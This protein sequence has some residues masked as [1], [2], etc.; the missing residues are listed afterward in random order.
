MMLIAGESL[1]VVQLNTTNEAN[2]NIN[3]GIL[4]S[5]LLI[6]FLDLVKHEKLHQIL[7]KLTFGR[8]VREWKCWFLFRFEI[9]RMRFVIVR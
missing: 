9:T 5:F 1:K 3:T 7:K 4:L 8:C 6:S 2:A